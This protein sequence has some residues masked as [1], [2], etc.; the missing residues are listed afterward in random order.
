MQPR[1]DRRC[2]VPWPA[3]CTRAGKT[4][5]GGNGGVSLAVIKDITLANI[6]LHHIYTLMITKLL[7]SR[8]EVAHIMADIS[9]INLQS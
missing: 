4:R 5:L 1:S 7:E 3:C 2:R 9:K 8:V 6:M